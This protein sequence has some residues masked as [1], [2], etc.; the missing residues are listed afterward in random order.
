MIL[1]EDMNS[2][3]NNSLFMESKA[4]QSL[5]KSPL[6]FIDIGARGGAHDFVEPVAKLAAILGFEPDEPECQR[7]LSTPD[8]YEPWAAFHLEPVAL[9]DKKAAAELVL[10]STATNHSLL[11]PNLEFTQ[12]YNMDKWQEVGRESLETEL[13]DTVLFS[14]LK[15][16]YNWGEVI[17]LDTQGTEYEILQGATRTLTE[18]TVAIVTEVAFCELYKGQK[19]F[20]EVEL[21]LREHGFSFY[22][23]PKIHGRSCKL[24]DKRTHVTAERAFYADAVFFKDPLPGASNRKSVDERGVYVLFTSALLLGY[25]DFALE[26]ATKTWATD[27]NELSRIQK[28]ISGLAQNN[29]VN[30]HNAITEL[31]Q[32]VSNKPEL[33]NVMV[34]GFVD[35]RRRLCNYDDVLNVSV[36]PK[37]RSN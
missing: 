19:L 2:L 21:L 28:L 23:F 3:A 33:A 22:G 9:A 35:T 20:S 17:K 6:G 32:R 8:V 30:T 37:T 18:R 4:G 15:S 36:A 34:G 29:P 16:S 27:A 7:L 26:L 13:L 25:Y 5:Q 11:P 1:P 31:A 24:L 12:R 10:L 14:H